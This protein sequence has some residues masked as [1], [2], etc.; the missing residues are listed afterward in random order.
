MSLQQPATSEEVIQI[1]PALPPAA[2]ADALLR[3]DV[4]RYAKSAGSASVLDQA[5]D[6]LAGAFKDGKWILLCRRVMDGAPEKW[7]LRASEWQDGAISWL[8]LQP[9]DGRVLPGEATV[10]VNVRTSARNSVWSAV[11]AAVRGQTNTVY[12]LMRPQ[13]SG[14]LSFIDAQHDWQSLID[15]TPGRVQDGIEE[16]FLGWARSWYEGG[17]VRLGTKFPVAHFTAGASQALEKLLCPPFCGALHVFDGEYEGVKAI[18]EAYGLA[19]TAHTR[20]D[21]EAILNRSYGD[22]DVFYVSAPSAIDGGV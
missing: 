15:F 4:V 5:E 18:A 11:C 17:R 2:L 19:V 13:T 16:E 22:H 9:S 6:T 3:L 8:E 20:R 7:F 1:V 12:G 14:I 21:R 10:R